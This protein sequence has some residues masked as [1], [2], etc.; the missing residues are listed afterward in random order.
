MRYD[1]YGC[2]LARASRVLHAGGRRAR[3]VGGHPSASSDGGEISAL[4][5]EWVEEHAEIPAWARIGGAVAV[6]PRLVRIIAA[7]ATDASP[8]LESL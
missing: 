1:W 2:P 8:L 5:Q 4:G 6:E 3:T 7:G